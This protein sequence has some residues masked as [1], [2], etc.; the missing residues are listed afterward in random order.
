MWAIENYKFRLLGLIIFSFL[1][2]SQF[3][4]RL[5]SQSREDFNFDEFNEN[6]NENFNEIS[7]L[8][9]IVS[10]N[11][12]YNITNPIFESMVLANYFFKKNEELH[13]NN[14]N[15]IILAS[16][17]GK[18]LR[19]NQIL[20]YDRIIKK[21]LRINVLPKILNLYPEEN[22]T[23]VTYLNVNLTVEL[24]DFKNINS[25]SF[26]QLK[27]FSYSKKMIQA[28][29]ELIPKN[30]SAKIYCKSSAMIQGKSQNCIRYLFEDKCSSNI[31]EILSGHYQ[32]ELFIGLC[33]NFF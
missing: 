14:Q 33:E 1:I 27:L 16:A 8:H 15:I 17:P 31:S 25:K 2:L 4:K 20:F 23:M 28:I 5:E 18:N 3:V 10:S 29:L 19:S 26:K 22:I 12:N 9:Q 32:N 30:S 6:F 21:T 7:F 13:K 11:I 24:Y